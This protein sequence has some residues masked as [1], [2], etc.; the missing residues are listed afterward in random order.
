MP[1]GANSPSGGPNV[2]EKEESPCGSH[3]ARTSCAPANKIAQAAQDRATGRIQARYEFVVEP[4]PHPDRSKEFLRKR[5][6]SDQMILRIESAD[7]LMR[8]SPYVRIKNTGTEPIDAI[9]T[10]VH[11]DLGAAYGAGVRQIE[12]APMVINETS[13]YEATAFGKLEPGH[14]A[15]IF[16]APLL[17]NQITRLNLKEYADKDHFGMF[18]VRVYC[19]LVGASSYDRMPDEKWVALM[20]HWRPAGFLP[21]AKHVK[22]LLE[23]KPW[24]VFDG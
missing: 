12:P 3:C 23:K 21:D 14:S 18:T 15:R 11:Y 4:T 24:I 20:F 7:E 1:L 19:R 2:P 8:W 9:K 5:E 10:D 17:L 16:V 13:T 22:E 6:G